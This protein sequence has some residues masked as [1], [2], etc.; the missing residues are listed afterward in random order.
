MKSKFVDFDHQVIEFDQIH[1]E[2]DEFGSIYR[3]R[4]KFIDFEVNLK[5]K[6]G[7]FDHQVIEF[8]QIHI[9]ID[10]FGVDLS[11]IEPNSSISM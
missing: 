4:T 8:G 10:E 9:E 1:I 2:I 6:F 7:D 11:K 5:S 3:N